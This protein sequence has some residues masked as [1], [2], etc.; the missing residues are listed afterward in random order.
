MASNK[1]QDE[2]ENPKPFVATSG[3]KRMDAEQAANDAAAAAARA[4]EADGNPQSEEIQKLVNEKEELK[5]TLAQ[6]PGGFRQLPQACGERRAP[7]AP[8]R[9]GNGRRGAIAGAGCV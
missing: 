3:G 4:F 1:D 8:S 7:G 9:R 5:N 2:M 6:A